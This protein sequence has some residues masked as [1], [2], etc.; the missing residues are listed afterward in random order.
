MQLITENITKTEISA[1]NNLDIV[2]P[3]ERVMMFDIETTGLSPDRS[4]IYM[5]GMNIRNENGWTVKLLFNDDGRSEQEIIE[6]FQEELSAHDILI[7]FNGDAF[8]I[9][10]VKRR[11]EHIRR[12]TGNV[13]KDNFDTIRPVDLMK[14]IR[15]Y[16]FALGLPNIKQKTV[17]RYLGI[18]RVDQFNGGQLIEVYLDYLTTKDET[19]K[20]LVV[21]HN[22][23][24]MVG[25]M[26]LADIYAVTALSDGNFTVAGIST[27]VKANR[28]FLNINLNLS[29]PM[30]RRIFSSCKGISVDAENDTAHLQIPMEE[31]T[32][33]FYFENSKT[34]FNEKTGYFVTSLTG[35]VPGLPLYKTELKDKMNYLELNDGFLGSE[36][37]IKCYAS[38]ICSLILQNKIKH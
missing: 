22:R 13:I 1:L 14:L 3:K 32:F 12:L 34:S 18:N 6:T 29:F 26:Y 20:N 10:F 11:M 2:Y 28:L 7:E 37:N 23:D 36:A 21:Q 4:F 5:I 31:G 17:E 30:P 19:A 25:M 33:R 35:E 24:D 27:E 16:K 15:P 38:N 9:N 8:D